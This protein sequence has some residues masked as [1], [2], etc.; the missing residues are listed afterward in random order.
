M[1]LE[2]IGSNRFQSRHYPNRS[3]F[4]DY[5]NIPNRNL[6]PEFA[7][8]FDGRTSSGMK[9]SNDEDA[10]PE[11][12]RGGPTSPND[13][14]ELHGFEGPGDPENQENDPLGYVDGNISGGPTSG[15]SSNNGSPPAK[16]TPAKNNLHGLNGEILNLFFYRNFVS[17]RPYIIYAFELGS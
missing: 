10:E 11:W 1:P 8:R 16:S 4:Q 5:G 14:V 2:P 13:F 9:T 12:Y 15:A 17:Y 3:S 7:Q 6:L